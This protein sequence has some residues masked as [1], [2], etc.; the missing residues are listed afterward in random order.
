[1]MD[2]SQAMLWDVISLLILLG[3][4]AVIIQGSRPANSYKRPGRVALKEVA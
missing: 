4:L 3:L 1:M 2:R